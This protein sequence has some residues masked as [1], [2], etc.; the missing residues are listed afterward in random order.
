MAT[1]QLH[2]ENALRLINEPLSSETKRERW[3][4]EG[5]KLYLATVG[6]SSASTYTEQEQLALSASQFGVMFAR[7]IALMLALPNARE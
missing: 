4:L 6:M 5:A 2:Y 3:T 1:N 7:R